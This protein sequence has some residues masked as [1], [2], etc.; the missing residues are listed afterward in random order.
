MWLSLLLLA[1]LLVPGAKTGEIIG[2]HEAE[3]HS[4]PY[5]AFLKISGSKSMK[6]GGFLIRDNFVLTAAHCWGRSINVTL[7]AHNLKV[8]EKTQQHISVRR[9]IVHPGYTKTFLHDIMILQ[10]KTKAQRTAAVR[11][12]NLPRKMV[13]PGQL[14]SVAGWGQVS[15]GIPTSTLHEATLTVQKD[16]ECERL[17]PNYNSTTEMCVGDRRKKMASFQGDSGGP[18]MCSNVAQGIVSYGWKDGT[19]PRVFT[20]VISYLRWIQKTIKRVQLQESD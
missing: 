20:K 13:R 11:P 7:G 2:G 15:V 10:L 17:F 19:P 8:Q 1:F 14:C 12:L 5:M 9:A 4:R 6:C 18:L 16:Q 3:P